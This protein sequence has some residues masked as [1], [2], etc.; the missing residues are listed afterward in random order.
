[1]LQHSR[2]CNQQFSP[3]EREQSCDSAIILNEASAVWVIDNGFK[4][5]FNGLIFASRS[6]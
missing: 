5:V 6:G 3:P 1:M 2:D 4:F